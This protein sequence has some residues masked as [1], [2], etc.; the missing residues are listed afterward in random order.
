MFYE[1]EVGHLPA[2]P[3]AA[4]LGPDKGVGGGPINVL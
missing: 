3:L 4:A 2:V 1:V